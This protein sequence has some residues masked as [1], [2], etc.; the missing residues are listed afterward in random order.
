MSIEDRSWM[1]EGWNDNGSHS[2]E[3]V[4]NTNAFLDRAFSVPNAEK[5]GIVCPCSECQNR[6]RRRKPV[7]TIHLCKRGFMPGYTLWTKHGEQSVSSSTMEHSYNSA[8]GLDEL[9]GDFGDA[10]QTDSVEEEPTADAKAFYDMLSASEVPLHNFTSVSRLTAVA[11]LMAIKSQHNLSAE[12]I[13]SSL[14]LFGYVLPEGHKMPSSLYECKCLLNGLKMPYVKIDACVNNCMIYY[15]QDEHKEKYDFCGESRYVVTEP[16]CQVRKRKPIPRKVLRYLP[17]IPRLQ[18]MYMEPKTAKHMRWHKEGTRTNPN[19][20]VHP[21]DAEAWQHFSMIHPDF[22]MEARNV[23]VAIATDGFNPF[24]FGATQYSCWPV[25]VIPL[26]LPP[27]LCMKEE[28]IFLS[29]AVPGPKHPGKNLNVFMRP[30][31]NEFKEAWAGVVTYDSFLKQNFNMRVKYHTSIHDFPALGMFTGWST[32][33]GLA[34][35]ECMADVD[36]TWLPNGRKHSW[37]DCHRRFLPPDHT[38]RNQKNAFRKGVA[39][40]DMPPRRLSGEEV[41]AYMNEAKSKSFEGF[42]TTHNWTHIPYWWELPYFPQLLHRTPASVLTCLLKSHHP[43]LVNYRGKKVPA[44]TWK[45]YQADKDTA[46]ISKADVVEQEFWLRFR[47]DPENEEKAR[48][49]VGN[50]C[51]QLIGSIMY[52]ARIYAT[53]E[54][55]RI[56]EHRNICDKI[57]GKFYLSRAQYVARCPIWCKED[58]WESMASEWSDTKFQKKSATNRANRYSRKFK[59]HKGGSNSIAVVRQKLSKKLGREVTQVEAWVHTHR[60]SDPEDPNLLNTEEATA[61]LERYKAKAIELNGPEFDWLHSPVDIRALY[62][63]SCGRAHG[64]WALFN[65]IVDDTEALSELK[66]SR[67]TSVAAKRKRQEEEKIARQKEAQE[68]RDSRLA[69][70]YANSMM[71]W[72]QMVQQQNQNFQKFMENL[73]AHTGLPPGLVPPPVPPP[74]PPPTYGV[75]ASPSPSLEN[76][77]AGTF[78]SSIREESPETTLNRIAHGVFGGPVNATT[79]GGGN[80]SPPLEDDFPLSPLR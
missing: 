8:D 67:T 70:E 45:H 77:S 31:V 62:D 63:C 53:M 65:G 74:P 32:H 44:S 48:Q 55:F 61:C 69:K 75:S 68:A 72:G 50:C 66:S 22:A 26:N 6:I 40:H 19:V 3:W 2:E 42:G 15:K 76:L 17:V 21:S 43:G 57:A 49:H 38:F 25:F 56:V 33:G 30:L 60:G 11:R 5:T 36:S 24:S 29:L 51:K 27:A 34:C 23:R 64:K 16:A 79:S 4:R 58:C 78:G 80:Y 12:C 10:M 1:Y 28:N 47:Y 54:H 71:Q 73:A 46:G 37:F 35:V 18:R 41:L 9:L 7:M 59:P 13:D 20:M 14:R 52:Y 39:V